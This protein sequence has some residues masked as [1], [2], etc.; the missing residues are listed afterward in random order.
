MTPDKRALQELR[1]NIEH[2]SKSIDNQARAFSIALKSMI[3]V[4][5]QSIK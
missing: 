2:L 5:D 4:L 1:K 3:K